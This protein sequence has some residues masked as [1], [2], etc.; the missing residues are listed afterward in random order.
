MSLPV[1]ESSAPIEESQSVEVQESSQESSGGQ[2]DVE[3]QTEDFQNQVEEA[4]SEGASKKEV[5]QMIKEFELKV[6]GKS[7]KKSIDL[8]NEE[9]VR[10][11]LQKAAAFGD[12]SQTHAQ[13]VKSLQAKINAWKSNPDLL[14]QDLE[15]DPLDY[16][17]K[18]IQKEVDELKKTPEE[19]KYEEQQ[20][21]LMEY[22][23]KERK[24]QEQLEQQRIEQENQQA[25]EALRGEI[26]DAFEG[27]PGLKYT[28]KTERRVAD[29]MARYSE[30]FPDVT[31][32]QVIPLV[33]KE[34]KEEMNEYLDSMPEEFLSKFLNQNVIDKIAKKV[35][36]PAPKAPTKKAPP[37]NST[38][39]V[40]PS[41]NSVKQN[42]QVQNSKPKKSFEDVWR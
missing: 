42:Q 25:Y 40:A 12:L 18:R 17:E 30:K 7:V 28:E 5:L 19:K 3:Q 27:H 37:V 2:Q 32:S 8:S 10:K 14:F 16:A 4:I 33:E 35:A 13:M 15:M 11:E 9:E 23:E 34:M 36:K 20:R 26:K 39:V 41:A 31:A 6:N 29:M 38:Q 1:T 22:E 24:L 21:K